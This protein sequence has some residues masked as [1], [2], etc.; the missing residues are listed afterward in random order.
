MNL[1]ISQ[2]DHGPRSWSVRT[3]RTWTVVMKRR[4]FR[5]PLTSCKLSRAS[6]KLQISKVLC[7]FIQYLTDSSQ[8]FKY[9]L[10]IC[11]YLFKRPI[12]FFSRLWW[13]SKY[14]VLFICYLDF[15]VRMRSIESAEKG[16]SLVAL[17][18]RDPWDC[19]D[20]ILVCCTN[21]RRARGWWRIARSTKRRRRR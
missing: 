1:Y 11:C 15:C 3:D 17:T 2:A 4:E 7:L 5:Y 21:A 10:I 18:F 19:N 16:L 8:L 13:L 9:L 12:T 20:P 14:E 6:L